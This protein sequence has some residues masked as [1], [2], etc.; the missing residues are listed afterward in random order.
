MKLICPLWFENCYGEW[1]QIAECE[2]NQVH[3]YI[4]EFIDK[5]NA[6]KPENKKFIS[7]YTRAW[8]EPNGMWNYDVGSHTEF[9]HWG[10]KNEIFT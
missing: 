6:N 5:C 2:K 10:I 1:R 7:Y 8:Q 3:L 4:K 9:F